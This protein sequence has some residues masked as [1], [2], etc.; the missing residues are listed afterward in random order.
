MASQN[1]C[2]EKQPFKITMHKTNY[3][4]IG[5]I[6]TTFKVITTIAVAVVQSLSN[7]QGIQKNITISS[8][9]YM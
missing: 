5:T 2:I 6:I 3:K 1:M 4:S 8:I 9:V 7:I